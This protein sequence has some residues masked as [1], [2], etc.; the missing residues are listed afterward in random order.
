M[1]NLGSFAPHAAELATTKSRT[2]PYLFVILVSSPDVLSSLVQRFRQ[3]CRNP[4]HAYAALLLR[5]DVTLQR[6]SGLKPHLQ[7]SGRGDRSGSEG[8]H[9]CH[10]RERALARRSLAAYDSSRHTPG[11]ARH[12]REELTPVWCSDLS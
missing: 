3:R 9:P 7:S 12:A 2:I 4:G 5:V 10:L 11:R 6:L 8:G 1:A